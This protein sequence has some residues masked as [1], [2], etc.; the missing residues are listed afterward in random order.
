MS[1]PNWKKFAKAFSYLSSSTTATSETIS[2]AASTTESDYTEQELETQEGKQDVGVQL[3]LYFKRVAPTITSAYSML[4]DE[5]LLEA[6]QT[7]FGMK[8]NT[9]GSIDTNASIVSKLMPMSDLTNSKKLDQLVERFTAQYTVLYSSGGRTH[10]RRWRCT[11]AARRRHR[12]PRRR[13]VDHER[14]RQRQQQLQR[15]VDRPNR[16]RACC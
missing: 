4:G 14:H 7:I 2:A 9:N 10:R 15:L 11:T 13:D 1:N 8:L 3:A 12:P 6:F 5:N 16:F